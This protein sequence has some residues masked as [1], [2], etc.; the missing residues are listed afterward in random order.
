MKRYLDLSQSGIRASLCMAASS[1]FLLAGYEFMRSSSTSLF[2]TAYGKDAVPVATLFM[3]VA[4]IAFLFVY[5]ILLGRFGAKWTLVATTIGSG[6]LIAA[7]F[8]MHKAGFKLASGMLYVLREAYVVL[9]IEQ[10]WSY[11]NSKVSAEHARKLNGPI[12]G[13]SSLGAIAGGMT[14]AVFVGQL[15]TESLLLF[16]AIACIPAAIFSIWA[17]N[18]GGDPRGQSAHSQSAGHK[19]KSNWRDVVGLSLMR[20]E[21]ILAWILTIVLTTV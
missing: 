14:T 21:P 1:F 7:G 15:G 10:Y 17:F 9:I 19:G 5:G 3:P 8:A 16:A 18:I 2:I 20:R 13:I 12:C 6:A 4:V 11:I